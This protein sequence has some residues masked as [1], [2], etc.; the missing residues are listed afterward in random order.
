MF[1]KSPKGTQGLTSPTRELAQSGDDTK[2]HSGAVLENK[3]DSLLNLDKWSMSSKMS[4]PICKT[5]AYTNRYSCR[6]LIKYTG[7]MFFQHMCPYMW[8]QVSWCTVEVKSWL[9]G[10][11]AFGAHNHIFRNFFSRGAR[12]CGASSLVLDQVEEKKVGTSR[13]GIASKLWREKGV[14]DSS[15]SAASYPDYAYW[16]KKKNKTVSPFSLLPT[17]FLNHVISSHPAS[18]QAGF[19]DF[20]NKIA[21]IIVLEA[22]DLLPCRN[23]HSL[24]SQGI[25]TSRT[26]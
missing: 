13:E 5:P 22:K 2:Q 1:I 26:P 11:I 10:K 4:V 18:L 23:K 8:C 17:F 24:H 12:T 9:R 7:Q 16:K 19:K 14:D 6:C 15:V 3:Y 20:R 21:L 25:S